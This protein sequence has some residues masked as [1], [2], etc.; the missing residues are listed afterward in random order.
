MKK[1]LLIVASIVMASCTMAQSKIS[2]GL[3]GGL[4]TATMQGDAA[5]SLKN[6]LNFTNGTVTTTSRSGFFGGGYVSIPVTEILSIEPALYYSQK[7]YGLKGALNL[8][9]A[10]FLGVNATSQLN[11]SYI[12]LPLLVKVNLSGLQFFAGPQVSY[13]AAADLHTTAGALGFTIVNSNTDASNQFNS[14]DAALTGGIGYVFANGV[15]FTAAYD[16]GLSKA[17][18]GKNFDLYN[19]AF[20]IGVGFRF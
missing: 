8:K 14:W 20:K 11:T 13:M 16:Y 9:G 2:F 5:N 17:D 10:D 18:A 1:Q 7:G 6:L 19:R 4:S 3:R 15:N 12:D